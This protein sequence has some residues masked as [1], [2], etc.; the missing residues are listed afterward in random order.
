MSGWKL[1]REF[2]PVLASKSLTLRF[3]FDSHLKLRNIDRFSHIL[4]GCH[5]VRLAPAAVRSK[6][7]SGSGQGTR[8]P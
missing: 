1:E 4:K 5:S 3:D 8:M 6:L 7:F 2:P